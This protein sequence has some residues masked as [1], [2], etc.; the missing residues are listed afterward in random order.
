MVGYDVVIAVC[1]IAFV[2]LAVLGFAGFRNGDFTGD[3]LVRALRKD[4]DGTTP[5]DREAGRS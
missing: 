3:A 4:L 1:M 2:A 5:E